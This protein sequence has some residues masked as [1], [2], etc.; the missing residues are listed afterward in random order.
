MWYGESKGD[1]FSEDDYKQDQHIR[2]RQKQLEKK[3]Q[4]YLNSL[5]NILNT[6]GPPAAPT[7]QQPTGSGVIILRESDEPLIEARDVL[8]ME[9]WFAREVK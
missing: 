7:G 6:F 3:Q 9:K 2:E 1:W 8:Q 5:D 4:H